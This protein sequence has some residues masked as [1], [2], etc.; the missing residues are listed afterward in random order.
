MYYEIAGLRPVSELQLLLNQLKEYIEAGKIKLIMDRIYSLEQ[1]AEA[2]RYIDKGHKK[3]NSS[4]NYA[5]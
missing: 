4:Y 1:T 5:I 2:N 3:G